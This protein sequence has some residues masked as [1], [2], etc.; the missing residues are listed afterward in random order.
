M[1]ITPPELPEGIEHPTPEQLAEYAIARDIQNAYIA[2]KERLE[3]ER[4]IALATPLVPLTIS[5]STVS[6]VKASAD[7]SVKDL[8]NQMQAKLDLLGETSG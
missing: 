3:A 6:A 1:T 4:Q 7:A 8:A 5:G 2:E